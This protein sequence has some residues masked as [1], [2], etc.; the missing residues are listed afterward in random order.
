M[1]LVTNR[2]GEDEI[3]AAPG[4]NLQCIYMPFV[5]LSVI[6]LNVIWI[7]TPALLQVSNETISSVLLQCSFYTWLAAF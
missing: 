7:G 3:I 6:V 5:F 4:L 2:E 1:L